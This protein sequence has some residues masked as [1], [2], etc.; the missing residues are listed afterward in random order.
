MSI[1]DIRLQHRKKK[2]KKVEI[3]RIFSLDR[4]TI[5]FQFLKRDYKILEI[6]RNSLV[7]LRLTEEFKFGTVG[8]RNFI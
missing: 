5:M 2:K 7:R 1:K 3:C 8:T 4:R 6:V